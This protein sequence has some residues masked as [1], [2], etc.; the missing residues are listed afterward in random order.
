MGLPYGGFTEFDPDKI[1]MSRRLSQ[2]GPGFYFTDNLK[3]AKEYLKKENGNGKFVKSD[4]AEMYKT[5]LSIKNP[6]DITDNKRTI[7]NDQ[8]LTIIEQG[9][10]WNIGWWKW[11]YTG[12]KTM[13]D[14]EVF[15]VIF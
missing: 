2:Q 6:L 10:D 9:G 11:F 15:F 13:S 1:S 7:T 12:E 3:W 4:E 14:Q 8:L 5:Y